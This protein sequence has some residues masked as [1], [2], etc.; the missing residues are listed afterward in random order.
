MA[1]YADTVLKT[2]SIVLAFSLA[3]CKPVSILSNGM[4]ILVIWLR[5]CEFLE[6]ALFL[7]EANLFGK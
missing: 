1:K 2:D 3:N 5:F 4:S 7:I 6:I